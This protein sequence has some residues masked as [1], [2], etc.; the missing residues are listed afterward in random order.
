MQNLAEL[1]NGPIGI[2]VAAV[3]T[4]MVYSYLLG[5]NPLYGLAEHLLVGSAV[6]YAVIV[7]VHSVLIPRLIVPL[8]SG[9]WLYVIPLVLGVLVAHQDQ[10]LLVAHG[11]SPD[12][13]ADGRGRCARH[14]RST[15]GDY[16]APG[17]RDDRAAQA[18]RLPG[19]WLG[20]GGRSG[21]DRHRHDRCAS[22]FPF[23]QG[24]SQ[25][26]GPVV[27]RPGERLGQGGTLGDHDR[28]WRHVCQPGHVQSVS[29]RRSDAV[30]S[31]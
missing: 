27:G 31:G 10:D 25:Q 1:L 2:W 16:L 26:G 8:R 19:A 21:G 11:Q 4:I 7:A 12:G 30:P 13:F 5:D 9:N 17:H 22:V 3:L 20:G 23:Q 29:F 15:A 6:A 14:E 28:F 24:Y 18:F